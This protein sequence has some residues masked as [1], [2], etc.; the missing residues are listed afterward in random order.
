MGNAKVILWLFLRKLRNR[1]GGTSIQILQKIN[2]K[3]NLVRSIGVGATEKEIQRLLFID[4]P[5]IERLGTQIQLFVSYQDIRIELYLDL[6][7][8]SKIQKIGPKLI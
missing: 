7:A 6:L 4:K 3:L 1:S 8:N 5:E 2:D